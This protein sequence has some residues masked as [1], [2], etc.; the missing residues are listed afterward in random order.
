MKIIVEHK[1]LGAP[2]NDRG[3]GVLSVTSK[4]SERGVSLLSDFCATEEHASML[5]FLYPGTGL[6][7]IMHYQAKFTAFPEYSR[8][9]DERALYELDSSEF[10]KVNFSYGALLPSLNKFGEYNSRFYGVSNELEVQ[11]VGNSSAN[12][13][14]GSVQLLKNAII[15]GVLSNRKVFIK[16]GNGD[17]LKG[18][19]IRNS[20]KLKFLL[21]AVSQLPES[22][23]R[24]VSVAY[25]VENMSRIFER[26]ASETVVFAIFDDVSEWG[27]WA[28]NSVV[29]DW[30]TDT[31]KGSVGVV[32]E[33]KMVVFDKLLPIY[34]TENVSSTKDFSVLVGTVGKKIDDFPCLTVDKA[35]S[36]STTD[37]LAIE[38]W[39]NAGNHSYLHKDVSLRMLWLSVMGMTKTSSKA[40]FKEYPDLRNDKSYIS[41]LKDNVNKSD[42]FQQLSDIYDNNK[43]IPEICKVIIEKVLADSRLVDACADNPRSDLSKN[44][45]D[46]IK[47]SAIKWAE[48][49]KIARLDKPYFGLSLEKSFIVKNWADFNRLFGKM[50]NRLDIN[51]LPFNINW[52]DVIPAELFKKIQK[53]F[54]EDDC[55]KLYDKVAPLRAT[56]NDYADI[57][58]SYGRRFFPSIKEDIDNASRPIDSR[59]FEEDVFSLLSFPESKEI[60]ELLSEKYFLLKMNVL[61]GLIA[62]LKDGCSDFVLNAITGDR[63]N[64]IIKSDDRASGNQIVVY[65]HDLHNI[66]EKRVIDKR[67]KVLKGMAD[68]YIRMELLSESP[69]DRMSF[70]Q[71][72]DKPQ[73][74]VSKWFELIA[75]R[76][77]ELG[78]EEKKK[79]CSKF[80]DYYTHLGTAEN[81][82]NIS[83]EAK[84]FLKHSAKNLMASLKDTGYVDEADYLKSSMPKSVFYKFVQTI[85]GLGRKWIMICVAVLAI[86]VGIVMSLVILKRDFE[87][88]LPTPPDTQPP[89]LPIDTLY[90]KMLIN[91]TVANS[92]EWNCVPLDSIHPILLFANKYLDS[93]Y[94]DNFSAF[95]EMKVSNMDSTF[96]LQISSDSIWFV[97]R[98]RPLVEY[99][100]YA[101][102]NLHNS[103]TDTISLRL[104]CI[105]GKRPRDTINVSV[106]RTNPLIM[107]ILANDTLQGCNVVSCN[108]KSIDNKDFERKNGRL[109]TL[110]R[111]DYYLWIVQQLNEIKTHKQK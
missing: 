7:T 41:L 9:Y 81:D 6:Y 38:R 109:R 30:T 87:K 8:W 84:L 15:Q 19:D 67:D 72:L 70:W 80:I 36:L 107:Q 27:E 57:A 22:W 10:E 86:I 75:D 14:K 104:K 2:V 35:K 65:L 108:G 34:N 3:D 73:K 24:Y 69:L 82:K 98:L 20:P 102:D 51:K 71:L 94:Q 59:K 5:F 74:C 4:V 76:I 88:S 96:C 40:V 49:V 52:S 105:D 45:Q 103:S 93:L 58:C 11:S 77:P 111:T 92:L 16:L 28:V 110:G 37:A 91:D 54:T 21:A 31:P 78:D 64:Q 43:D 23:R 13:G 25:G 55:K 12:A 61:S 62:T 106:S 1:V 47:D 46:R 63:I 50:N 48:D 66:K 68:R 17:K 18:D 99:Y 100:S 83:R 33:R 29:I 53:R 32:D 101:L 44:L 85:K 56:L 39:F 89:V 42:S 79:L 97:S 26:I 95:V 90:Y 60:G